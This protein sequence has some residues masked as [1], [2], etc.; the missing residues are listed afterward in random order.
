MKGVET[1]N[2][3]TSAIRQEDA[4]QWN[5]YVDS[6]FNENGS[7][8]SMML[9]SPEGHKIHYAL[10]FGFSVSN[11]KDEYEALIAGMRLARELRAHNLKI[12]SDS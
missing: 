1:G 6:A 7:R 2:N 3:E 4:D 5:L 8:A 12:Y 11:N 10:R 9:I